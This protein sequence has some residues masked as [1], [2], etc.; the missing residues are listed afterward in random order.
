MNDE[1]R[2]AQDG[3]HTPGERL[4]ETSACSVLID[5]VGHPCYGQLTPG[6]IKTRYLLTRHLLSLTVLE[7]PVL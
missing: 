3:G 4:K 7:A 1:D 2:V 6:Q 5:I